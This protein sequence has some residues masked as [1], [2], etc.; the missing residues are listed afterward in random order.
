MEPRWRLTLFGGLRATTD[1][2]EVTRFYTQKTGALLAYLAYYRQRSHPRE[3]LI[4]LLWPESTSEAG[5]DSLSTALSWLRRQ[6]EPTGAPAGAVLVTDRAAVRLNPTAVTTDVEEFEAALQAA[7]QAGTHPGRAESLARAV[8][9]Y[10]G[11]LLTGCYDD[12][13]LQEREWLAER[14][15]Q[16]LGRLIGNLEQAGDLDRALAVA[17]RGLSLDPLR[18]EAHV[19]LMR[20]YAAAGQPEAALRQYGELERLLKQELEATPSAA[21]RALARQI[22]RQSLIRRPPPAVRSPS[23]ASPPKTTPPAAGENRLVTVLFADMSASV[24]AMRDLQPEDAAALVNRLLGVM[25]D[26]LLKYEGQVDRF[27]GDGVLAVF[28]VLQA[29]EDDAERAIRA[30]IE[31][32]EAARNLGLE[33][34]AG[35]NTGVVYMGAVGSERHQERTVVGPVVNLAARLQEQAQPGQI[36]AGET[37][38]Y[39]SRRAFHFAPVSLTIKGLPEPVRAYAVGEALPRPEKARGIEGRRAE[40]IGRERE[41]G[42]LQKALTA[43]E[44]GQGQIVS[45]IGE[46]GVG[47]SRLVAELKLAALAAPRSRRDLPL[48]LEG[49]CLELNMTTAYSPFLDLLVQYF[50]WG[51]DE[52]EGGRVARLVA[53]LRRLVDRGD[54]AAERA[55]EMGPLLGN[56]FSL[57]SGTD[58]DLLLKNASPEQ[59][60]HQALLALQEFFVALARRQPLVL[61]LE[62]LHWADP[63]SLDLISLLMEALLHAPLLLLCVYR[64]EREH[65]CWQLATIASRKCPERATELT[66]RELT[67]SQCRRLVQSLL[68]SEELPGSVM[69]EIVQQVQGNPFFVEEV[70]HA[71]IEAGTLYREGEAWRT[72]DLGGGRSTPGGRV[73]RPTPAPPP[74]CGQDEP[75]GVD[76]GGNRCLHLPGESDAVGVPGSVQSVILSRLD[77][78]DGE[79]R[80]VLESA[81]VMGRLFRRHLLEQIAEPETG[82]ERVLWEL[83]ERGLIYQ[84]R[85]VPEAEYSFKHVLTQETIYGSLLLRQ[86][87]VLHQQVAEA[88]EALYR[89]EL[90]A[91]TEQLSYHYDRSEADEK[92]IEYLL[93]AGEKSRRAY[94]NEGAIDYF[95]RALMRLERTGLGEARKAWRLEALEKLGRTYHGMGELPAAEQCFREAIALGREIGLAPRELV[96]LHCALADTAMWQNRVDE[97]TRIA[98]EALALLGGDIECVEAAMV[99]VYLERDEETARF[100]ARLPYCEEL[101]SAYDCVIITSAVNKNVDEA[102]CWSRALAVQA[103]A[104]H[105]LRALG[106]GCYW[107]ARAVHAASGDLRQALTEYHQA[108]EWLS[109]VGDVK[110]TSWCAVAMATA[111]LT[112]GEFENAEKY[113]RL[114]ISAADAVGHVKDKVIGLTVLATVA[115]CHQGWEAAGEELAQIAHLLPK[116]PERVFRG[117]FWTGAPASLLLARACRAFGRRAETWLHLRDALARSQEAGWS[118]ATPTSWEEAS[119]SLIA[120]TLA[121]LEETID[122]PQERQTLASQ[123]LATLQTDERSPTV[124]GS[125]EPTQPPASRRRQMQETIGSPLPPGWRWIDPRGDGS[126]GMD[127][128]LVIR[129][130]NGRDLHHVNRSAPRLLRSLSGSVAIQAVCSRTSGAEPAIGGL[131][132]WKD[133][134]NY[135]RLDRGTRGEFEISF[136]GCV[137][138]QEVL[139]GRGWLPHEQVTLRLERHRAV[140]RAVC[141]ADGQSWFTVGHVEFPVEDPLEV[142]VHAIGSI[143]RTIYPGAYS[144]GTAIRFEAFQVWRYGQ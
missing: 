138:D 111:Y 43:V 106:S 69:E 102:L 11:E 32:R 92:A 2:R 86:R 61:V 8:E 66:L 57:R 48:W 62:D 87:A 46:A 41:L 123:L 122:D 81:S 27:L 116:V 121:T 71:L 144:E 59:I 26:A 54:L 114:G 128:G 120:A 16:A 127:A 13:V 72:R 1:D 15:F 139:I 53:A 4:E 118:I 79:L 35:I 64:P 22:E 88:V 85:V 126:M 80:R 68:G 108:L 115:C 99:N 67:P 19:E 21:T 77:R 140:V 136:S 56:L 63:R 95:R 96:R 76:P 78:L 17:H 90:D 103:A 109:R 97:L 132:L 20:L 74:A 6:L 89:E 101:R 98:E 119:P 44:N 23:L 82:I 143:D 117:N 94:L 33:V 28:G 18:E 84:E 83:E 12:W 38:S 3:E 47:K 135:L 137:A 30:A 75:P 58:W 107:T 5:R 55:V 70:V 73:G 141:S 105:D 91:Y 51:P 142:G 113:A 9:L 36:L 133:E 100:L 34:T 39:Q 129:A 45:L 25:V 134:R 14:Y 24:E 31:F 124:Q 37:T 29:H 10:R 60:R 130:A 112:L 125:L 50:G 49:R 93:K 110:H 40:L 65:K 131:L 42:Q 7:A 104:H 52:P